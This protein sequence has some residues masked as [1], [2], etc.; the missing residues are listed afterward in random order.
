MN[1]RDVAIVESL[2]TFRVLTRDQLILMHF[3]DNKTPYVVANR[4]LKRLV[5]TKQIKVS[6]TARMYKYFPAENNIRMDSAKIPHFLAIADFYLELC[7]TSKPFRFDVE[8]KPLDK[9]G[10]EPDAFMIWDGLDGIPRAFMIEIQRS[11]YTKKQMENKK[12]MYLDYK[13]AHEDVWKEYS[14]KFPAIWIISEKPYNVDFKPLAVIQSANVGSL[15][16]RLAKR[17]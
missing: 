11:N 3:S 7:Q 13:N 1:K 9:G 17:T 6:K 14:S 8:F 12:K 16:K 2:K 15:L 4:V 5:D 10:I